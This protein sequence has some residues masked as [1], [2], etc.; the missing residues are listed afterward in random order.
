MTKPSTILVCPVV[1]LRQLPPQEVDV[2]RRFLFENI[3]GANDVHDKRW[4]HLWGRFW[5]AEP[6]EVFELLN[7]ADRSLPFHGRWMA[8]EQRI[9]DNQDAYVHQERFRDWLKTGSGFGTYHLV[10][11]KM[12]FV[13]ASVS[14]E[15][16]SDDEMREFAAAALDFLHTDRAL[17]KLWPHLPRAKR[18][19]MLETVLRDPTRES[20]GA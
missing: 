5:R 15:K 2:I 14:Y 3:R 17:R 20:E 11:G 12:K 18:Q 16:C 13:P 9:F 6:G 10:D 7:K 19:D 8:I 1:P 4:R